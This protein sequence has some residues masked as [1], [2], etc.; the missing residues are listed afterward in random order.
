MRDE[1]EEREVSENNRRPSSQEAVGLS[2]LIAFG[3]TWGGIWGI[4]I[5]NH[6][7]LGIHSLLAVCMPAGETPVNC[8]AFS[9]YGDE[10]L[11]ALIPLK[12]CC[13]WSH[14][15]LLTG[16]PKPCKL[17]CL[18]LHEKC[19]PAPLLLVKLAGTLMHASYS[20]LDPSPQAQAPAP[21]LQ[22][23]HQSPLWLLNTWLW[24]LGHFIEAALLEGSN[25][26]VWQVR[27]NAPVNNAAE[28]TEAPSALLGLKGMS[29]GNG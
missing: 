25:Y 11:I 14:S 10:S 18:S 23:C 9:V 28:N 3:I 19:R 7:L 13:N 24:H 26:R 22:S 6:F 29:R 4:I 15:K 1:A 5:H 12:W 20:I 27:F 17:V 2:L 8:P 21:N 16:D